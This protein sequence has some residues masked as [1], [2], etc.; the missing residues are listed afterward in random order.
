MFTLIR[1]P[2]GL[3]FTVRHGLVHFAVILSPADVIALKD[4]I[5]YYFGDEDK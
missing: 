5:K 3:Q 2:A 1:T 4:S